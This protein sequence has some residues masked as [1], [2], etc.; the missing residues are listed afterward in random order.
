MGK[1]AP[2]PDAQY[3]HVPASGLA[4][5]KDMQLAV[6]SSFYVWVVDLLAATTQ[7]HIPQPGTE[8]PT[9]STTYSLHRYHHETEAREMYDASPLCYN[10]KHHMCFVTSDTERMHPTVGRQPRCVQKGFLIQG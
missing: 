5:T 4:A 7:L 8:L 6:C 2:P 10:A 9:L 3:G 1:L